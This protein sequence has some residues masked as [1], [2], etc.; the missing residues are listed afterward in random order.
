MNRRR[1]IQTTGLAA[2]AT[3][4]FPAI[5]HSQ[6]QAPN[7][8]MLLV[9]DLNDYLGCLGGHPQARTPNMDALAESGVLFTNAHCSAPACNPSRVN[10]LT[11]IL[12]STSGVYDNPDDWQ[13]LIPDAITL[14]RHLSNNGYATYSSGK[15]EHDVEP[16]VWDFSSSD[17]ST[18]STPQRHQNRLPSTQKNRFDWSPI[19]LHVDQTTDAI[20]AAWINDYLL[21]PQPGANLLAYGTHRPHTP[22]YCPRE[23]SEHYPQE[24][25][26]MPPFLDGD[27]DDV[28]AMGQDLARTYLHNRTVV[29]KQWRAAV[30]G[31]LAS[32]EFADAMIGRGLDA[33]D[34][35]PARDDTIIF[36]TSD[37]GFHLGEKTNWQKFALWE[38]ATHVPLIFHVPWMQGGLNCNQ[39]VALGDVF[40]TVSD[41]CNLPTLNE[42]FE[43]ESLVPQLSDP[44]T[45]RTRPALTTWLAGNHSIRNEQWRYIRYSDGTEELY[46]HDNDPNEWTNLAG[47]PQYRD[48]MDD[49]AQW[50]PD[51]G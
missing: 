8:L 49:L 35:S 15:I 24:E 36:L 20:N 40:P 5:L 19:D 47:D 29:G 18:I 31:Y 46:D 21:N 26:I 13:E 51:D 2:A 50:M 33:W 25:I 30:A 11:S 45:P 28:P 7:V 41:L 17:P 39:G 42:Q 48:M 3:S 6:P 32:V 1:F 16:D 43:G 9:D 10:L 14:P 44:E 12:P 23:Y 22:L 38:E 27:L 37:H 34:A 4:A